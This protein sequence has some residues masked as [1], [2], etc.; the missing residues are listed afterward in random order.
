MRNK[1]KEK[2]MQEERRGK[3]FMGAVLLVIG[4]YFLFR[5]LGLIY[6][7]FDIVWPFFFII[8]GLF[9]IWKT[10]SEK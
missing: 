1:I 7:S 6:F 9:I 2:W 3:Y 4:L 10:V 5:N 8:P